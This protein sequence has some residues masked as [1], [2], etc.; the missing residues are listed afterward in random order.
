LAGR[1]RLEVGWRASGPAGARGLWRFGNVRLDRFGPKH[2]LEWH[3]SEWLRGFNGW[4]MLTGRL[5]GCGRDSFAVRSAGFPVEGL[6]E[7]VREERR[8]G[9]GASP[10]GGVGA[11]PGVPRGPSRMAETA[12]HAAR[13]PW[14]KARRRPR[15]GGALLA[16]AA[17]LGGGARRGCRAATGALTL[18]KKIRQRF[19][20][21][22]LRL[23]WAAQLAGDGGR[24]K[25]ERKLGAR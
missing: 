8:G 16:F 12:S 6:E 18:P 15:P 14:N 17:P 11:R 20:V 7:A 21:L 23:A 25:I 3:S 1:M 2:C 10:E 5:E 4:S 9:M 24:R 22:R 19:G 13:A